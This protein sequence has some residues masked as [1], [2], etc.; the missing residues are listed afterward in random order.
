LRA[1]VLSTTLATARAAPGR[2]ALAAFARSFAALIRPDY[3]L[4]LAATALVLAVGRG[5]TARG[6]L[7]APCC[8]VAG[9]LLHLG[10]IVSMG[11]P[12]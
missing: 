1:T 8:W 10:Y 9:G 2:A 5:S 6:W 11:A 4:P 3:T 12:Q 7:S